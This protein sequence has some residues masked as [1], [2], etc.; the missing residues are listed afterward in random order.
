MDKEK[1]IKVSI[2]PFTDWQKQEIAK[3][4]GK[5]KLSLWKRICQFLLK[6]KRYG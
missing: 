3:R 2:H 4:L 5:P 6:C 1:H